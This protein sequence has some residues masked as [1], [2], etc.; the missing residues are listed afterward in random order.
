MRFDFEYRS[1]A[2]RSALPFSQ[3]RSQRFRCFYEWTISDNKT[4]QRS[5]FRLDHVIPLLRYL[6]MFPCVPAI[7]G[8]L[9]LTERREKR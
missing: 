7:E 8:I 2:F 4:V 9:R 3:L 1:L 6:H 5:S